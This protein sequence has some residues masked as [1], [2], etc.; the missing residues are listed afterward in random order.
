MIAATILY[1]ETDRRILVISSGQE[2]PVDKN[3]AGLFK[4]VLRI[5]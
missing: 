3:K 4:K 5:S 1:R 2:C